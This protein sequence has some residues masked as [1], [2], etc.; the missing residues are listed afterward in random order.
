MQ[1]LDVSA[2]G[3]VLVRGLVAAKVWADGKVEPVRGT[4][5]GFN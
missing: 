1:P 2:G 5:L 4:F 3:K